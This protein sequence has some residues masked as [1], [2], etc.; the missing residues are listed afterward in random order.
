MIEARKFKMLVLTDHECHKDDDNVFAQIR[1]LQMHS[2][3]EGVDVAS[4]GNKINEHFFKNFVL[5]LYVNPVTG[6]FQYSEDSKL[7]TDKF[8]LAKLDSYQ[9]LLVWLPE[10]DNQRMANFL[11]LKFPNKKIVVRPI[12]QI[13]PLKIAK[14][15]AINGSK[16]TLSEHF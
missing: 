2:S 6:S 5:R 14:V 9:V 3:C 13:V 8:R 10:E 11:R 4:K 16:V 12:K 1:E 7:F 15:Q